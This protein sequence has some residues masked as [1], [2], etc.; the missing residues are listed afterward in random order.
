MLQSS[1]NCKP[2]SQ[3]RLDLY[4]NSPKLSEWVRQSAVADA[5]AGVAVVAV[6]AVV[7]VFVAVFVAVAVI[8]ARQQ[9]SR[10]HPTPIKE[11]QQP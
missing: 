2:Q 6:V 11:Q 5:V 3:H 8:V 7:V 9:D 4:Q 10:E 1:H